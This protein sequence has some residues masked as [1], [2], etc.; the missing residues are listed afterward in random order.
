M[1]DLC[2]SLWRRESR[3]HPS[4]NQC[5]CPHATAA[6]TSHWKGDHK[7]AQARLNESSLKYLNK[8]QISWIFTEDWLLLCTAFFGWLQDFAG[9]P[10]ASGVNQGWQDVTHIALWEKEIALS[11]IWSLYIHS[12][13][14]HPRMSRP[15]RAGSGLCCRVCLCQ[16]ANEMQILFQTEAAATKENITK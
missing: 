5:A 11:Q 1:A 10:H 8:T 4:S 14:T 3:F 9:P 12:R 15:D 16:D 13:V 2:K 6:C 7:L